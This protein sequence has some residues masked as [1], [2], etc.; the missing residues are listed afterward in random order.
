LEEF[1]V[2]VVDYEMPTMNGAAL[3]ERLKSKLPKLNV[4]LYSAAIVVPFRDLQR[5]DKV[6]SKGEGVTVLLR[7]LC[8]LSAE[9][10]S[11]ERSAEVPARNDAREPP[12]SVAP[13]RR[14]RRFFF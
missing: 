5:V 13:G 9:L 2:A 12:A 14:S 11:A 7:Y 6:I 3:A 1:D 4:I 8:S 10:S